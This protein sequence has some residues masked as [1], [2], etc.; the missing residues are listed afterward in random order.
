MHAQ[1]FYLLLFSRDNFPTLIFFSF[2]LI[3]PI[4]DF[5]LIFHNLYN[6]KLENY[7]VDFSFLVG[8]YFEDLIIESFF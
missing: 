3:S 1:F 7:Y 8:Y 4:L 5:K 6:E 2:H